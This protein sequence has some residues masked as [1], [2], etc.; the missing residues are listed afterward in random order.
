MGY[1]KLTAGLSQVTETKKK[2]RNNQSPP[3]PAASRVTA[4]LEQAAALGAAG[5]YEAA[6]NLLR[7]AGKEPSLR[8]ALAVCLMRI[9]RLE[10]AIVVL[11][12]IV[13]EPA[14]AWIRTD[15]PLIYQTNFATA[16]LLGGQP[17]GCVELLG[18]ITEQEHP[19]VKRLHEAVARWERTLSWWDYLN[20]KVGRINPRRVAVQLDFAPGDF[21]LTAKSSEPPASQPRGPESPTAA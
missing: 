6:A 20:W 16:L 2:P 21:E 8:N 19:A 4:L 5:N 1:Q 14:G 10:E 12:G 18:Q 17:N 7:G 11:R 13:L 15:V 3:N 9:G